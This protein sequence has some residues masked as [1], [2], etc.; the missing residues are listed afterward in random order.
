[1]ILWTALGVFLLGWVAR[2][3][4]LRWKLR[5]PG[6]VPREWSAADREAITA[7]FGQHAV[8]VQVQLG[9]YADELAGGDLLLRERLRLLE[10]PTA[11]RSR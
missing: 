1:M 9:R 2:D 8:A 3:L 10:H 6:D 7:D 11:A 5:E 4:L